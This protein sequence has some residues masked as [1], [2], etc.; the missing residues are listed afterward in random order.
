MREFRAEPEVSSL[1]QAVK[2]PPTEKVRFLGLGTHGTCR[3]F[4]SVW[5]ASSGHCLFQTRLSFFVSVC[6]VLISVNSVV[7]CVECSVNRIGLLILRGRGPE[8]LAVSRW[9]FLARLLALSGDVLVVSLI[10]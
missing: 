7:H 1:L 6:F 10:V 8:S 3:E 4:L 9:R 2:V 5:S